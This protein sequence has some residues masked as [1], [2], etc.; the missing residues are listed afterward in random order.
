[1][2]DET[3]II[4]PESLIDDQEFSLRPKLLKEFIG[5]QKLK[6]NLKVYLEGKDEDDNDDDEDTEEVEE[7]NDGEIQLV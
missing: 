4:S 6:E 7:D 2:A 5:Q 1:M 3:R